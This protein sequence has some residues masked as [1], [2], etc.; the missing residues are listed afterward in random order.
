VRRVEPLANISALLSEAQTLGL[1]LGEAT[2]TLDESGQD[3][4]ALHGKDGAGVAWVVRSPRRPDVIAAAEVEAR[5]LRL[6]APRL[7]V[8][9]PHWEI[10]T[11]KL[12]AYRR[13]AG[14]P[15]W[16]MDPQT[17]A[18]TWRVDP[19]APPDALLDGLAAV[20]AA[21][22]QIPVADAHVA[23]LPLHDAAAL[24][25]RL[26][27]RMAAARAAVAIPAPVWRRW[28]TWLDDDA[29]WP[30]RCALAHGD[31]H[32]GHLLLA[33]PPDDPRLVGVLDWT[34]L[35]VTDP[36]TDVAMVRRCF[37]EAAVDRLLPRLEAMGGVTWPG[38]ARHTGEL[39]A[40]YPVSIIEFAQT[41]GRPELLDMARK[42]LEQLAAASPA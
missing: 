29:C 17:Y 3:F 14:E 36:A 8:A 28:Q 42:E 19:S 37:G 25:P 12:I 24:R 13:L 23:G 16:T 30:E 5:G 6:V 31:L 4:I 40:S 26:A 35:K 22:Q 18:L 41:A 39:L 38:L 15:A 7:P 2:A 34:E 10:H 21:L 9:V 27:A 1:V 32:P 20:I 33:A 11:P